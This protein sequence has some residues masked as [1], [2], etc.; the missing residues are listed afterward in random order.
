MV[1][2]LFKNAD[3]AL[4]ELRLFECFA[5]KMFEL[6]RKGGTCVQRDLCCL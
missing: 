3:L 6:L 2:S 4:G 1:M 5:M